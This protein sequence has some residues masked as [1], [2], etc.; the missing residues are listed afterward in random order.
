MRGRLYWGEP[1]AQ[2]GAPPA[3]LGRGRAELAVDIGGTTSADGR[4]ALERFLESWLQFLW[5]G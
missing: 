1:R 5:R 3:D 4:P 2:R